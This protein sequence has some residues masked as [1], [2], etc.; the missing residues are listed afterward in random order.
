MQ[1]FAKPWYRLRTMRI[2]RDQTGLAANAALSPEIERALEQSEYLV[3]LASPAAAARPWIKRELEWWITH[4]PVSR[5]LI[6]V[7]DGE[8]KW[9]QNGKD[10]DWELTNALPPELRGRFEHEPLYVD[11]RWAKAEGEDVLSLRHSRFRSAVLDVAAALLNT[12]KDLLDGSDVRQYRRNR[13]AAGTA[14]M[15]CLTLGLIAG[16][17]SLVAREQL[18]EITAA[19]TAA[20][21]RSATSKANSSPPEALAFLSRAI[22]MSP[23]EVGPRA[24]AFNLF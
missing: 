4:R 9:D 17:Q 2:F 13:I 7:T 6:V 15:V 5:L 21:L 14:V 22:R 16:W 10:F 11:L 1:R 20:D 18:A 3:L 23:Q 8:L 12:S 19:L 24:L